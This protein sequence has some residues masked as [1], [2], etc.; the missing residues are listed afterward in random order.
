MSEKQNLPIDKDSIDRM[1]R[2]AVEIAGDKTQAIRFEELVA[3]IS[4]ATGAGKRAVKNE[5]KALWN[6]D[7]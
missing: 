1:K 4:E 7:P 6:Q 2:E 3:A 5:I